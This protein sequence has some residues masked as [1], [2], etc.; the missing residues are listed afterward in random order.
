[1]GLVEGDAR[2]LDGGVELPVDGV[3]PNGAIG[4]VLSPSKVK[5][6]T[7]LLGLFAEQAEQGSA[8]FAARGPP[9]LRLVLL[10]ADIEL[11]VWTDDGLILEDHAHIRLPN[12]NAVCGRHGGKLLIREVS[13]FNRAGPDQVCARNRDNSLRKASAPHQHKGFVDGENS[14]P[15]FLGFHASFLLGVC[16]SLLKCFHSSSLPD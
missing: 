10:L 9:G 12:T 13:A 3:T 11:L 4:D 5:V 15:D 8:S 6:R 14:L 16:A 1:M 7:R 2:L